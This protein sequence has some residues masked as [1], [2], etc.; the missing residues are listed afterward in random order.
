MPTP[1]TEPPGTVTARSLRALIALSLACAFG[2]FAFSAAMGLAGSRPV[3]VIVAVG[4]GH[5]SPGSSGGA[6]LF[7]WMKE[8]PPAP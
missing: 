6:R 1:T 4:I 8:R 3:A 5:S 2:I 7:R